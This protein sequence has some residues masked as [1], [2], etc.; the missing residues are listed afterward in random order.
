MLNLEDPS[1]ISNYDTDLFVPLTV[2]AAQL[3]IEQDAA[4]DLAEVD[5]GAH[6]AAS[7]R[8]IADHARAL[9]F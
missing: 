7:L 8:V 3:I 5:R 2:R 9:R 6:T 1:I 4:S